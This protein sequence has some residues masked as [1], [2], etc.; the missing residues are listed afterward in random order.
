MPSEWN[1][2]KIREWANEVVNISRIT[3]KPERHFAFIATE[4][5]SDAEQLKR[6]LT[7][8]IKD[9]NSRPTPKVVWGTE[10]WMKGCK[11]EDEEGICTV[12]RSKIP[13]NIQVNQDGSYIVLKD[14]KLRRDDYG[15]DRDDMRGG[16]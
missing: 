10:Y 2:Y 8:K 9:S 15:M 5:R 6:T 11:I 1:D 3:T 13:P 16:R 14:E 4:T 7:D 12:S